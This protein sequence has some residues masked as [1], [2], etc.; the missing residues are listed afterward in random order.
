MWLM[1]LRRSVND[2]E[3]YCS[4]IILRVYKANTVVWNTGMR[5][6]ELKVGKIYEGYIFK[7]VAYQLV[8]RHRD[9]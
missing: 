7:T 8:L 1:N 4:C 6:F 9:F 3:S 5:V 2:K